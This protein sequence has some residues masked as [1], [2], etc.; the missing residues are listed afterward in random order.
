VLRPANDGRKHRARRVVA[1]EARLA[2]AC[3]RVKKHRTTHQ[4]RVRTE[5]KRP[6]G[7]YLGK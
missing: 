5:R 3:T 1:G 7:E 4:K 2:H 6:C